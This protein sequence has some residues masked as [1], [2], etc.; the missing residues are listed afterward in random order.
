LCTAPTKPARPRRRTTGADPRGI[1][2]R[3]RPAD[4]HHAQ[5]PG[6]ERRAL[7]RRREHL[8]FKPGPEAVNEDARR[9]EAGQLYDRRGPELDKG[10]ERHPLEIQAGCGDVLAQVARCDL[11]ARFEKRGEELGRD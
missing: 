2:S 10:P 4:P 5:H 9:P 1:A 3:D 8:S 11:E 6:F 7:F